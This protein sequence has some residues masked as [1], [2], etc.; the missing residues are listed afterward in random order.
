MHTVV[1]RRGERGITP[2]T[3]FTIQ[4]I[5]NTKFFQKSALGFTLFVLLA[6]AIKNPV[7]TFVVIQ[8][9]W[10]KLIQ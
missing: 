4:N 10:L 5:P 8:K 6:N 1:V 7:K 3:H 2:E 9:P